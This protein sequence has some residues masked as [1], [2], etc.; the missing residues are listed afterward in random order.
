MKL[1]RPFAI[2]QQQGRYFKQRTPVLF[3]F[4]SD[5][6]AHAIDQQSTILFYHDAGCISALLKKIKKLTN[7]PGATSGAVSPYAD[8]SFKLSF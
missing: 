1:Q 2:L 7:A 6:I 3:F 4:A 8:F 5:I